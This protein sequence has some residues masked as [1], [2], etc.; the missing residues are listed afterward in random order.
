V[1]FR[2]GIRIYP[3]STVSLNYS[4]NKMS[5]ALSIVS[6]PAGAEAYV[7][8][9]LVG[10][11][12]C[13]SEGVVYGR[14][15]LKLVKG[16][17]RTYTQGFDMS[18]QRDKTEVTLNLLPPGKIIFS[19]EPYAS[20][21]IDGKLIKEDATYYEIEQAPGKHTVLLQHPKFGTHTEDVEVKSNESV[22]VRHR[23]SS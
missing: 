17:Y 2:D 22:T 20:V 9:A 4:F 16:G 11:T 12:P 23:F 6:E 19:I 10:T 8:G 3:D 7:D 14:H 18:K 5:G 15:E 1:G 21:S 13:I